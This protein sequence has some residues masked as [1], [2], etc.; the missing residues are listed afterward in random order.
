MELEPAHQVVLAHEPGRLA[1][2]PAEGADHAHAAEDLGGLAVDLLALLA[3]VAEERPDPPVP[4]QVGIVDARHQ[5]E[6]TE[7]EPPVD[8]GQHDQS[9][10]EL[11]HGPPGVVEHAEDQLAHAA[12]VLAQQARRPSRLEL[13]DP[14][15]RQPHR[16]LVDLP[17]DGHL[18]ALGRPRRQPAAP[19]ARSPC[20]GS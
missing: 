7:Q 20:P 4:D 8:P 10:E 16:V 19:E 17:A 1:L 6:C 12:G 18:H 2:L 15:Q 3:D 5:A 13:V 11:D 14:V 9:A